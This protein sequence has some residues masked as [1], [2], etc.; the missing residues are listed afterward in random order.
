[1]MPFSATDAD[2]DAATTKAM[3][4][5]LIKIERVPVGMACLLPVELPHEL[6]ILESL[7][8]VFQPP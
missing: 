7:G 6:W 8:Q 2:A 5:M 3:N 4:V 1:M